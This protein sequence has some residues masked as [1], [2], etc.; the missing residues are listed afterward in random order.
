MATQIKTPHDPNLNPSVL[1]AVTLL[2]TRAASNWCVLLRLSD[3]L[4]RPAALLY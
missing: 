2:A 4:K 1:L 3:S